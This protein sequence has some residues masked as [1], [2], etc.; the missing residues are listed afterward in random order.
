MITETGQVVAE[1]GSKV[2]VMTIRQSACQSCSARHGC[3]QK[4]LATMSQGKANQI[5]VDNTLGAR[6]GDQVTLAIGESALLGASLL[7]YALPLLM[8][9]LGAMLGHWVSGH[10]DLPALAGALAGL[11]AGFVLVRYLMTRSAGD[12]EPRMTS[13]SLASAADPGS[14]PE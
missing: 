10:G 8:L 14:L 5:L 7:V 13:V 2:W 11:A 3:G 4:A 9:V 6:V 1:S 12:W